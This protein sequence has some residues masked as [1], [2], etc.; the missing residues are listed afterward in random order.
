MKVVA[1]SLP[2]SG[3]HLLGRLLSCLGFCEKEPGLTGALLR[4]TSRNPFRNFKKKLRRPRKG[5][6]GLWIDLDVPENCINQK[7]LSRYIN[8]IPDNSFVSAHLPYS[9]ALYEFF[10]HL[11]VKVIHIT[12]DPRD[13]LISYINYQKKYKNY[14]FF[15]EYDS[16]DMDDAISACFKKNQKGNLVYSP[17]TERIK[18]GMGWLNE[19]RVY[20]TTFEKLIGAKGGG[21]DDM[22]LQTIKEVQQ[23]LEIEQCLDDICRVARQVFDVHSQTFHKGQIGQWRKVFNRHQQEF[24]SSQLSGLIGEL[25]YGESLD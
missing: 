17:I 8:E 18:N 5:E 11:D 13:V 3:T 22:Q 14:S 6:N 9:T 12:R 21:S 25:G 7:W 4:E 15:E 24:V 16:K 20:A 19:P 1:N 23:F 10:E 2:K